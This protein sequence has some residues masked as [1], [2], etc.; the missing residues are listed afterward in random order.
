[1]LFSVLESYKYR[2]CFIDIFLTFPR[3][4]TSMLVHSSGSSLFM[5]Y[6]NFK[7]V[8]MISGRSG[9]LQIY[10]GEDISAAPPKNASL[11][12]TKGSYSKQH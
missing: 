11:E 9:N 4:F 2:F 8:V 7:K 12:M 10:M 5:L 3:L 6:N 1:M